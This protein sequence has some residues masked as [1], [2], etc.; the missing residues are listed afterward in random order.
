MF[1]RP[2]NMTIIRDIYSRFIFEQKQLNLEGRG[3]KTGISAAI[4][5]SAGFTLAFYKQFID[6]D[7]SSKYVNKFIK[8][9]LEKIVIPLAKAKN[10]NIKNA[11]FSFSDEIIIQYKH[12]QAIFKGGLKAYAETNTTMPLLKGIADYYIE[13]AVEDPSAI[14]EDVYSEIIGFFGV[15]IAGSAKY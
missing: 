12:I 1:G 3:I 6:R 4:N 7:V 10:V 11:V 2:E 5:F 9:I 13:Y 14:T 15:I 8:E